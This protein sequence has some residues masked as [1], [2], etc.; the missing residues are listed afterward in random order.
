[1]ARTTSKTRPQLGRVARAK[2]VTKASVNG[3]KPHR[4]KDRILPKNRK[5]ERNPSSRAKGD[6]SS[7]F[8]DISRSEPRLTPE[9]ELSLGKILQNAIQSTMINL[10]AQLE[11]DLELQAGAST[12]KNNTLVP[13]ATLEARQ[14]TRRLNPERL[15]GEKLEAHVKKM[16]YSEDGLDLLKTYD[17]QI[18]GR[19]AERMIKANLLL[20][21]SLA[22]K[23]CRPGGMPLSELVQEGNI[24]LILGTLRFDYKLGYRFSTYASWWIRHAITRAIADKAREIRIPVHMHD[25]SQTAAKTRAQLIEKLGRTPTI[26][27]VADALLANKRKGQKNA[28]LPDVAAK[29]RTQLIMKLG[30]MIMQ[31]QLPISLQT[32]FSTDNGDTTELGDLIPAEEPE[33]LKPWTG[34]EE[35]LLQ[36]AMK[37]LTPVERDILCQRFGIGTNGDKKT[38][39]REIGAHYSLTR[40]RIRQIQNL[41]LAKLRRILSRYLIT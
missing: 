14:R 19:T 7:Y 15:S 35:G 10:T 11:S 29:K 20:V 17:P 3:S 6:L 27:E 23:Y 24:G 33:D 8:T 36:K 37:T 32:Q 5:P 31:T 4:T 16:L 34:L 21:V 1:M 39:L 26:E 18:G 41:A 9:E 22:R 30:K 2:R 25:F 40:E 12:Y 38:T 13:R 28:L